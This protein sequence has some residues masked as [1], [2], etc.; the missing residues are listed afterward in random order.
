MIS[1]L[2]PIFQRWSTTG[3]VYIISDTHFEDSDCKL[4]DANWITPQ[5]HIDIIKSKVHKNDVLL[6]LGD[7]GCCPHWL[8][9][10]K[11][12]KVLIQGNHDKI[13]KLRPYFDE[14]YT[15]PLI[16]AQQIMLSHE[17]IPGIN[18]CLNIHGHD[19]G[20]VYY[21]NNDPYHLNIASNVVKYQVINL[22]TII[23]DGYLSK[24]TNI[25][26]QTIDKA[27]ESPLDF[28]KKI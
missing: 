17:P 15:G 14:V 4:M 9:Q 20:G 1:S 19:H 26:R 23:Q 2:Y 11:G 22:K 24:I 21:D 8:K 12:Y 16:I 5:E 6:H 28:Y 13:R 25:H 7:V 3:S 18:W 10:I 27:K